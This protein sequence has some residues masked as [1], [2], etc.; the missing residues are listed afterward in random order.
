MVRVQRPPD[1]RLPQ[2]LPSRP[3]CSELCPLTSFQPVLLGQPSLHLGGIFCSKEQQRILASTENS[4]GGKYLGKA[5]LK[6]G[7]HRKKQQKKK[8]SWIRFPLLKDLVL[9]SKQPLSLSTGP[10]V[11]SIMEV[12]FKILYVRRGKKRT[13]EKN[14]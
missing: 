10:A 5:F 11:W 6:L 2:S 12:L 13:S 1:C 4:G 7:T 9:E 8:T 14:A 3:R